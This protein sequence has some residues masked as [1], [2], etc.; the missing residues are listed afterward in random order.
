MSP[1]SRLS[2]QPV[3]NLAAD[4]NL[5]EFPFLSFVFQ[6]YFFLAMTGKE[7]YQ[8]QNIQFKSKS[9]QSI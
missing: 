6:F 8:I 9:K 3:T 5:L 7:T 2:K 1:I 4:L